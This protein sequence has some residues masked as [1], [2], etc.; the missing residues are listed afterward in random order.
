MSQRTHIKI[1]G[2]TREQDLMAALALSVDAL[3]F[4]FYRSSPRYV[5]PA[6][7][8]QLVQHV[9]AFVTV[10]GVFVNPTFSEL[11]EV[12]AHVPLTCVQLH[13]DE[14]ARFC[15][16]VKERYGV[17]VIRVARVTPSLNLLAFADEFIYQGGCA[18]LLLDA[19][20]DGYGGEGKAF[21][22]SLIP[23]EWRSKT[24]SQLIP[25]LI[26]S[27]GLHSDNVAECIERVRPYAVDVSSGVESAKGIKDIARM[28]AFVTAVRQADMRG[29]Q[30]S[31]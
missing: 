9:P 14:T 26:L 30:G 1:C 6:R 3:G 7:A 8:R 25:P 28:H 22:W 20:V 31:A 24:Y 21:D 2:I 4:I 13:G 19:W 27:G 23:A 29:Q 18:G 12:F 10:V 5:T 15:I 11:T 16:E 17:P